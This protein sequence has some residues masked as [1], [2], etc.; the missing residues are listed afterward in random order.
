MWVRKKDWEAINKK[1][2][3]LEA[4]NQSLQPD[5]QIISQRFQEILSEQT[6][7]QSSDN[8]GKL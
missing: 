1:V 6:S 3:D 2:A 4:K 8:Q 5:T 7:E